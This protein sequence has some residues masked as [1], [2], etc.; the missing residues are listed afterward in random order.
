MRVSTHRFWQYNATT[1]VAYNKGLG[2]K[3]LY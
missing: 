1:K 2:R 3:E